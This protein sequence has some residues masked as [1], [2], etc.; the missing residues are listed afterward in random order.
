VVRQER[1]YSPGCTD[2]PL[3]VFAALNH[4]FSKTK[5]IEDEEKREI[6]ISSSKQLLSD[7]G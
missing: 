1:R 6:A 2:D 7:T 5:W 3:A 4:P